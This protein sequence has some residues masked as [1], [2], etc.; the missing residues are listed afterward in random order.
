MNAFVSIL[1]GEMFTKLIFFRN[2]KVVMVFC[3]HLAF[4]NGYKCLCINDLSM[5]TKKYRKEHR[6][7]TIN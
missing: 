3:K 4:V 6:Y 2:E 7:V 1:R 5:F